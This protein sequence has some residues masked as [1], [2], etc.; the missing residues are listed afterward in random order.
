[1]KNI[2]QKML[3]PET[4][5]A[6]VPL[7]KL[8]AA[9]IGT[10]AIAREH[11]AALKALPHVEVAGLCDLSAARA[12]AT[13]ERFGVP[14]W[15]TDHHR[16]L[17]EVAP[18][19]V[20]LTT[21][22]PSHYPLARECLLGGFNVL[23]EKPISLDYSQF[24]ELRRLAI[25]RGCLLMENQNCRFNGTILRVRD[26]IDAGQLGEVVEVQVHIALNI[27]APGSRFADPNSPH[28]CLGMR[29]G[30]IADFLPHLAYLAYLF[31]GAPRGLRTVWH[32][33]LHAPLWPADEF[34]ASFTGERAF[35]SVAFSSSAQ[36]NGFWV[37]VLG[38]KMTCETNLFEPPRLIVRRLR[39][40]LPPINAFQDGLCEARDVFTSTVQGL[41]RKLGGVSSYDGLAELLART[42]AALGTGGEPPVPLD[43]IDAVAKLVAD[44]TNPEFAS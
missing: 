12:E 7:K 16:M 2:V 13:A 23:C 9:F 3:F 40:G 30:A 34:R 22:P 5:R 31:A 42:Y 24:Q 27:G 4:L 33:R 39:D 43:E 29:G 10:G 18:D 20:H 11:L 35:A 32:S 37:R 41:W 14:R 17:E 28:P 15:Y 44:F 6:E 8:R 38:T 1:M 25:G 19:L 21:P 26:F 36:P